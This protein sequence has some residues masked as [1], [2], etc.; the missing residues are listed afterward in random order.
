L[1]QLA[2]AYAALG[3]DAETVACVQEILDWFDRTPH[4][5]HV[6]PPG[7][8]YLLFAC[9][10]LAA[11]AAPEGLGNGRIFGQLLALSDEQ[12][13]N[14]VKVAIVDEGRGSLASAKG[15]YRQ[16]VDGFRS[17]VRGWTAVG[18]SYDQV[19]ALKGL[20]QALAQAGD[21]NGARATFDQ[22]LG[23]VEMLA[24][25]LEDAD[26]RTSFLNSPLVQEVRDARGAQQ[27]TD[28]GLLALQRKQLR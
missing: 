25:Q 5:E 24:A 28:S 19:R 23:V 20:G 17:A 15:N 14:P 22:A 1:G 18:R 9:Q 26:L 16:A 8:I 6:G 21:T 3:L 7:T 4:I 2:R 10:W 11:R 13:N 27:D 12:R